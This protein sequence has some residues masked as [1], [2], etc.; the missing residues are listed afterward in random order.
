MLP[1]ATSSNQK[2]WTNI[3]EKDKGDLPI[4]IQT[5]SVESGD[6][7]T[8]TNQILPR[9]KSVLQ[10]KAIKTTHSNVS[11]VNYNFN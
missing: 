10:V 1:S 3:Q 8:K 11:A 7:T 4:F 6:A 5:N 9:S 2:L